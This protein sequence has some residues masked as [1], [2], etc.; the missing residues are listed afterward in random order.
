MTVSTTLRSAT[1]AFLAATA[2]HFSA[3]LAAAA[4]AAT[5]P[6]RPCA[7]LRV[8]D[9]AAIAPAL[10]GE[11]GLGDEAVLWVAWT[12]ALDGSADSAAIEPIR[13]AG[14]I[15]WT[16]ARLH[17]PQPI[18]QNL[19]ALQSELAE[20][21][22][23]AGSARAG[24]PF[25]II[26]EPSAGAV[27]AVD[28]AFLVKRASVAITGA[29][30]DA[31]VWIGPFVADPGFLEALWG[32]EIAAYV[33]GVALAPGEGVEAAV[34]RLAELDPG[35]PL[36]LD[37]LPW[38]EPAS[39]TLAL[40]AQAAAQG[41]AI[42]LF[43]APA[44]ITRADLDPLVVL[45]RE[46]H[47]DI[48]HDPYTT[49]DGATRAWAFVRGEDLGLRVVVEAPDDAGELR[50]VI[51]DPQ[52]RDPVRID[53][54]TRDPVA[55]DGAIAVRRGLQVPVPPAPV[56]VLRVERMTPAELGGGEE[57][58]DVES[59]RTMPVEEILR[60]L[61]A[62]EDDQ[63]RKIDHY[64]ARNIMHLRFQAGPSGIEAAYAGDFFFER[65]KGFDWVWEEFLVDGVKWR[66]KRLPEIP[67]IQPEKA[68]AM[69]LEILFTKEYQYRLRGTAAVDGR[70]AWVVDFRPIVATA[71]RNLY[72]GTVWVDRETYSRVRTRAIQLGLE[73]EVMSNEE[74]TYFTPVDDRG[75]PV[76]RSRDSF[77]LPTRILS[78]QLLS[79]LNATVPLETESV[80]SAL[81]INDPAFAANRAAAWASD[82]TMVRDTPDGLR[83]LRSDESGDR[84]V[85]NEIDTD[86]LF[87]VGGLFWDE[88]LDYP[89]PLAGV[90]YLA[91]DF[92]GTGNQVNLFAA[93]PLLTA[94]YAEPRLFG[95]KWDAGVNL[96]GFFLDR[97][98][99]L[100]RDGS[101]VPAEE[102]DSRTASASFYL[103]HPIGSFAKLDFGYRLGLDQYSRG[104]DTADAFVVPNDGATHSVSTELRYDRSGYRA[105]VAGSYHS[106]SDW[107]PWGLPGSSEF[108]PDQ[109][110]YVRWRAS[111]RKTWW[112]ENFRTLG[113]ELTHVDGSDLDRFSG[114]DFGIFGD[115]SIPGYQGG[116]VRAD[117]ATGLELGYGLSFGDLLRFEVEGAAA[118]ASNEATGLD[119]EV[120]AGIGLEGSL[121]LPWQLLTNF[122]IGIG[123]AGPGEGDLAA[124]I[125]FLKLFGGE[126]NKRKKR[127]AG[128]P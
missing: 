82:L 70:D 117:Q 79:I 24:E 103:G 88:S 113:L 3:A 109:E 54:A 7:G 78:Q 93:G 32:E 100:F 9:P 97:T 59:E 45:A 86:R 2:L 60:R 25:Q 89:V 108:D 33:D 112:L 4:V 85:E 5:P 107:E 64:Q 90:N 74:T 27:T 123:V 111:F 68:A 115:L 36:A 58:L 84:V 1:L 46:F 124:R 47:G 91:L 23:L 69:P 40:A 102:I 57:R 44:S 67:L 10:E 126:G 22:R 16:T 87:V 98:D 20:L 53:L 51:E 43:E 83:Y 50:L 21:A 11:T 94:N 13:A 14:A 48:S 56:T 104:D 35:K 63:A 17:A 26:W 81:R 28:L 62:F 75:N 12:A 118:M 116:L 19:D 95:S 77:V 52:L 65:G 61:Q 34:A 99:E 121:P 73:G 128:T 66:S 72:Q 110:D 6:C 106:R 120:L 105:S 76:P 39:R 92:R 18:Q 29:R 55:V 38:P 114:Y 41:V 42:A 49:I 101:E 31:A 15:P 127:A 71:G 125:V 30:S 96:F 119:D 122:E 37:A 8:S 80:L